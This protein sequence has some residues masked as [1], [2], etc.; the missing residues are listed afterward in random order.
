M[1]ENC[2]EKF[3]ALLESGE[4]DSYEAVCRHLGVC[5]DDMDETLMAELGYTGA[6]VYDEY[7]GNQC[8][9]Y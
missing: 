3:A 2:Y 4:F 1:K 9:N 7:F 8:E 5:P 6:Q